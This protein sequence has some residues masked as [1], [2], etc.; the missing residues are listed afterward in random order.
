[1]NDDEVAPK[2][3]SFNVIK[4]RLKAGTLVITAAF[5]VLVLASYYI[6][7]VLAVISKLFTLIRK[8]NVFFGLLAC[9]DSQVND[10]AAAWRRDKLVLHGRSSI[11]N[12][13]L[14]EKC[15]QDKG[16]Q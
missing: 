14:N 16:T 5:S 1:M 10:S 12:R 7:M 8:G 6:G 3:S 13:S 2:T 9:R 4:H 15:K 11:W